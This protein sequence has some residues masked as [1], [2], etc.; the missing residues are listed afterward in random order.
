M[1]NSQ[2]KLYLYDGVIM[3]NYMTK[4]LY[5]CI[6]IFLMLKNMLAVQL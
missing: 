3:P 6:L 4:Y 5:L 1:D 2:V